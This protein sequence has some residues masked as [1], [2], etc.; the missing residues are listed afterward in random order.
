MSF[1]LASNSTN[2]QAPITTVRSSLVGQAAK[3]RSGLTQVSKRPS[4]GSP[5]Q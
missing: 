3:P 5:L 2:G 1:L 4:I